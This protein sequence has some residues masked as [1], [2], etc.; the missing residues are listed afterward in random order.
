V[1]LKAAGTGVL[2]TGTQ[3]AVVVDSTGATGDLYLAEGTVTFPD[4]PGVQVRPGQ[5]ARLR[6]GLPPLVS[7]LAPALASLASATVRYHTTGVWRTTP[8]VLRPQVLGPAVAAVAVGAA[9]L[10]SGGGGGGSTTRT[11]GVSVRLPF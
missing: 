11:G 3:V 2:I 5:W 9:V 7:T 4:F 10:A 1:A 8:M 6:P